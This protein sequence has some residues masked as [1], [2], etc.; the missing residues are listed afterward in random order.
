MKKVLILAANPKWTTPLRLDQEVRDI[1]AG[2][3]RSKNRDDFQLISKHAVRPKDVRRALLDHR[4]QILHFAG[5][6]EGKNGL[7]L[8]DDAGNAKLVSGRALANLFGMF[9]D[10]IECVLLNGCYSEVQARNIVEHINYVI[11]M[12]DSI[13]D[14]VAIEFSVAFYDAL[15]AGRSYEFAYRFAHASVDLIA[16]VSTNGRASRDLILASEEADAMEGY[17]VP[18]LLKRSGLIESPDGINSSSDTDHLQMAEEEDCFE[19]NLSAIQTAG[20][21]RVEALERR[22]IEMQNELQQ[23]LPEHYQEALN[24][25]K[26]N[27]KEFSS[28]ACSYAVKKNSELLKDLSEEDQDDFQWDVEKY[29][30]SVYYAISDSSFEILDEPVTGPSIDV[31]EAYQTAFLFIKKKVPPRFEKDITLA[32]SDRFD[33]LLKR[34]FIS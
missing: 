1:R 32:I 29:I 19:S 16:P 14:T 8:E 28:S 18:V 11:G 25:L 6:G 27:Q 17:S 5:H 12:N 24:W 10:D 4:P 30:E 13:A 2:L 33:Y 15:G 23:A 34:L 21:E 22:L 3:E 31:P 20:Q 7:V 26:S 9:S